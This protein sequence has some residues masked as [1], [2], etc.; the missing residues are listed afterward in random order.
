MASSKPKTG[1]R[2]GQA[3]TKPASGGPVAF[4]ARHWLALVLGIIGLF[5]LA[6]LLVALVLSFNPFAVSEPIFPCQGPN[7]SNG[8]CNL[9]KP[10]LYLYPEKDMAVDVKL[11]V[12]GQ[13]SK[14]DPPYGSGW[15]VQA[16]PSGRID[17]KYR[18]LD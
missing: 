17:G 12:N 8:L 14:D 11:H 1:K 13:I 16:T 6:G 3:G 5:L 7:G 15:S 2:G 4:L 9:K 10:A 18:G